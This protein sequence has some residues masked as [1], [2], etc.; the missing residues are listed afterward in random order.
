MEKQHY[1]HHSSVAV[2]VHHVPFILRNVD[3]YALS[4][5]GSGNGVIEQSYG[6]VLVEKYFLGYPGKWGD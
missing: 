1:S 3:I 4:V 6:R 2:D 5:N